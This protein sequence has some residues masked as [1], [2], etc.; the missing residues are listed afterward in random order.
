[1]T[2]AENIAL[3]LAQYTRLAPAEVDELVALK[4]ALVGLRGFENYYPSEISGGMRKR[5]GL[6]RAMALDPDILFLDEPSGGL[7]PLSSKRLDDLIFRL[8]ETQGCT[9]VIVTHELASIFDVA[10]T[11]LFL[12]PATH[13]Q[14]ALGNPK[15][16]RDHSDNPAV[17]LFLNRGLSP[18]SPS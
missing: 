10:D 12:D 8:R 9:I 17:R 14:G 11:A 13:M 15:H 16:L 5:A 3:P 2:L 7:D 1:M 18:N 4:L 6:A